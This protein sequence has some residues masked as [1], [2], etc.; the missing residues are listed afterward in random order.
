MLKNTYPENTD[1][2]NARP[3]PNTYIMY[4]ESIFFIFLIPKYSPYT[5]IAKNGPKYNKNPSIPKLN[6]NAGISIS[7]TN[8]LYWFIYPFPNIINNGLA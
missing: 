8:S 6:K 5:K 4:S 7:N 3:I 1:I 2:A